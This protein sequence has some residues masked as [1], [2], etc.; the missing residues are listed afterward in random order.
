MNM[1]VIVRFQRNAHRNFRKLTYALVAVIWLIGVIWIVNDPNNRSK[2]IESN[3]YT[4]IVAGNRSEV[5]FLPKVHAKYELGWIVVEADE[6]K[7]TTVD[8]D[9]DEYEVEPEKSYYIYS[10]HQ[11]EDTIKVLT[12]FHHTT[13]TVT[14]NA[15]IHATIDDTIDSRN[16]S[17]S[18]KELPDSNG[19]E[20]RPVLISCSHPRSSLDVSTIRLILDDKSSPAIKVYGKKSEDVTTVMPVFQRN[21]HSGPIVCVRPLLD[22]SSQDDLT[23]QTSLKQLIAYY[24]VNNIRSFA[25]FVTKVNDETEL[26]LE[27][28]RS[29][30][31]IQVKVFN[32]NLPPDV[33]M[34][35]SQNGQVAMMQFCVDHFSDRQV[36]FA[37]LNQ[38]IIVDP[39]STRSKRTVREYITDQ[40]VNHKEAAAMLLRTTIFCSDKNSKSDKSET[41]SN[42]IDLF[43]HTKRMASIF[44]KGLHST[45]II[46]KPEMVNIIGLNN[47]T[48]VEPKTKFDKLPYQIDANPFYF[49]N[50]QYG[51]CSSAKMVN[52]LKTLE[53]DNVIEDKAMSRYKD[54]I[55]TF[56]DD[57][58]F[59]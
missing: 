34:Y 57:H 13:I 35:V 33:Q 51:N 45:I 32:W 53:D 54:A 43:T 39:V 19:S 3:T 59:K 17:C 36:I 2:P 22:M 15:V 55:L 42:A 46:I 48:Y 41:E 58:D 6:H 29:L 27:I 28:I 49:V 21:S 16:V 25:F 38:Y 52:E 50:Y 11:T 56:C 26:F 9:D 4:V 44:Q 7:T 31:G 18:F 20:F 10:A 23:V 30:R 14:L 47:I 5:R 8:D 24:Y 1:R 12:I 37:E 40:T